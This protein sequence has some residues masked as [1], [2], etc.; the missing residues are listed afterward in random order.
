MVKK[1][2]GTSARLDRLAAS[3]DE[4]FEQVERR[5]E[6]VDRRF[7]EVDSKFAALEQLIVSENEKTRRHFDVTAER[8]RDERNLSIDRA[9]A[10]EERIAQLHIANAFAHAGF[11][12]RLDDCDRRLSILEDPEGRHRR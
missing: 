12:R 3:V 11:D 5:F 7:D 2:K 1:L 8:M 10:T 9:N 4:R 6:Q